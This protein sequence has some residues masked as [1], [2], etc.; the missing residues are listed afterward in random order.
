MSDII[1]PIEPF[2]L[3]Q[4]FGGNA[5]WYAKFGLKGHNGWDFK[6][7]WPD[8]PEGRR[9]I[10]ASWKMLFYRQ[11]VDPSGYGN[12]FET[13]CKLKNTYKLTY[14]HC[15]SIETFTGKNEG[16]H[17][18]ISDNTGNS[19]G[20]HLHLTVKRIKIENGQHVVY[21]Y[22]NGYFG[23][24]NPQIFFDELREYKKNG[25]TPT[26]PNEGVNMTIEE[27][28]YG[29]LI[30]KATNWDETHKYLELGGKP[31]DTTFQDA[32]KVISGYKSRITDVQNQLT[33]ALTNEQNEK[34]KA[35]RI[36]QSLDESAKIVKQLQN[37]LTGKESEYKKI[38]DAYEA[39]IQ[40]KEDRLEAQGKVIGGLQID[41]AQCKAGKPTQSLFKIIA[42]KIVLFIDWLKK[43]VSK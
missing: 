18:A 37:A 38:I 11:G 24:I 16:D 36:Q 2:E 12:F 41:L 8:T 39:T 33:R 25:N 1:R 35:A 10:L 13:V 9:Y 28:L 43:G 4:V 40:S 42:S 29:L 30:K 31:D 26:L 17:M 3:T 14:G 19:T 20:P 23:A 22:N 27:A 32:Q 5:E 7:R 15:H 21:D 34:D 6:T